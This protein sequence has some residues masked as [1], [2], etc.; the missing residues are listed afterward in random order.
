MGS[1][2]NAMFANLELR[3]VVG[4]LI[5]FLLLTTFICDM[6]RSWQ[7]NSYKHPCPF[8]I[9]LQRNIATVHFYNPRG[10]VKTHADVCFMLSLFLGRPPRLETV[11]LLL[12]CE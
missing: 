10:H 1:R 4:A 6:T 3:A 7:G 11:L 9:I 12:V 2:S 8:F 5:S